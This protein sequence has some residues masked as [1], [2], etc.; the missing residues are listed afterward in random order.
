MPTEAKRRRA[1]DMSE[2]HAAEGPARL[3]SVAGLGVEEIEL[4]VHVP[5]RVEHLP[6]ALSHAR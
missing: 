1:G 2:R 5:H 3:R 4:A 6:D